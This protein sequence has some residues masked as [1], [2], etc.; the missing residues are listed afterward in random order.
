MTV[1]GVL[2]AYLWCVPLGAA[3]V[4]QAI[5]MTSVDVVEYDE[6]I[7][8]DIARNVQRGGLPL[9]SCG[10][11]GLYYLV[12]PPLYLYFLSLAGRW[13]PGSV[14]ALRFATMLFGLGSVALVFVIGRSVRGA[15]AGMV[16]AS[17]LALNSFFAT[18]YFF[19]RMEVPM[20][21]F[22][23][24]AI[25]LLTQSERR[26][27]VRFLMAAGASVAVAVLLKEVALAFCAAS[28]LY[29][30]TSGQRWKHRMSGA[31]WMAIPTV[32]ALALWVVWA[33]VLDPRQLQAELSRWHGAV[34]GGGAPIA[35]TDFRMGIGG[36]EWLR[37]AGEQL[38]GWGSVLL[39]VVGAVCFLLA[40]KRQP[41]IALLLLLYILMAFGASLVIRLKEPRHVIG[42]I[43]ATALVIGVSINW[44]GLWSSLR[45]RPAWLAVAAITALVLLLDISPL[46]FPLPNDWR[47]LESWWDP[48]FAYRVFESDRYYGALR[49]TGRYLA[50]HTPSDTVIAVVHEGPV[51]G[52]YADRNYV[53]LYN[54]SYEQTIEVLKDS[55]F[56]VIDHIVFVQQSEEQI[57]E[58][59]Q[60]VE[61]RFE[62]EQVIEDACRQVVIYRRRVSAVQPHS[63]RGRV[64]VSRVGQGSGLA[65]SGRSFGAEGFVAASRLLL[66]SI[67]ERPR[68]WRMPVRQ[69]QI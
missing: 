54:L 64:A 35:V 37:I 33:M 20:C 10:Q 15:L 36:V 28:T 68:T 8:L 50:T 51:V 44:A 52:Y 26:G 2:R 41:R 56:L 47:N 30:F 55:R 21:F 23:I 22:L 9:R 60:Y 11:A 42:L 18:Y 14:F 43:P 38:L 59:L 32:V 65:G 6:A 49:E 12:D 19:I 17:L 4:I 25:Y 31:F 40:R 24:L 34:I 16:G 27:G 57:E 39:F 13:C 58:V 29:V 67:G 48:L 66:V 3:L 1:R 53:F 46:R 62:V 5:L 63:F 69:H 7:F 61:E 45:Q